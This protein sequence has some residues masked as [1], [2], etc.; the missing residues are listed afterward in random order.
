MGKTIA[1]LALPLATPL[2]QH[3]DRKL[4]LIDTN[5]FFGKINNEK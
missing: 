2:Y 1:F 3:Y 4:L 5:Y